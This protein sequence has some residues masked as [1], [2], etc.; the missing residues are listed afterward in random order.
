VFT[1]QVLR[2]FEQAKRHARARGLDEVTIES[3]L[4]AA[5][6]AG[7]GV[8]LARCLKLAANPQ[9]GHLP[10][11][12]AAALDEHGTILDLPM[13]LT[14]EVQSLI[15]CAHRLAGAVP[16][17][18]YP[19]LIG[20]RP[21]MCALAMSR[22]ACELLAARPISEKD[23]V[24]F[25]TIWYDGDEETPLL[26]ELA[27]RL[28]GLRGQLFSK[29]FGQDHAVQAFVEGLFSAEV[30]A[31]ADTTRKKPKAIFVFAGP[32]GVGKTYMA[33]LGAEA[34]GRP[35]RRFDMSAYSDHQQYLDLVGWPP[36]FQGAKPG[37]LTGYVKENPN[38]VL[39]FDEIEKAHLTTIN[40][41]LQLLDAGRLDDKFSNETVAFKDTTI[42]FTTN[43]GA[44][45]YDRPNETGVTVA[46]ASFHRRTILDALK[47]EK[48]PTGQPAF[49]QAICSR[50]AT[51]FPVLFNHLQVT[52][53]EMIARAELNRVTGLLEG[54]YFKCISYDDFLPLALVLR[55]GIATDARTI[56]AQSSAFV[57]TELFK[58]TELFTPQRLENVW[59]GTDQLH[60]G[61]ELAGAA[62][63]ISGLFIPPHPP[64][65]LLV[66]SDEI[67]ALYSQN[68][69][70]I[71]WHLA[72]TAEEGLNYLA[73]ADVDLILLDIWMGGSLSS[74]SLS[75]SIRA[76]DFM[77]LGSR[78]VAQG[79][80]FLRCVHERL[81]NIPVYLL[82]F[83]EDDQDSGSV[84]EGLLQACIRSGGAR[85]VCTTSFLSTVRP[86]W[87][88]QRQAFLDRLSKIALKMYR[89]TKAYSLGQEQK[90]LNFETMPQVSSGNRRITIQMKNL[91]LTRAFAAADVGEV[92]QN[93]E[94]PTVRFGDVYG[95]DSAKEAL[96]FVIDWLKN[97]RRYAALGIRP[98]KGILLTGNPG[99]GKTMLAR[100][101]AGESDVA[102]LVAS[103]TD[104]VT[105]WQGSGPQNIRDLFARARRY[106]PSIVFI[107][108]IDAVG[109]KRMGN[110]G[111][112]S[113]Q[114]EE[115]TLNALLTEMDGFGAPS[116]KPVIVL[117]ATNLADHLDD[118]LRRRFDREIE[119]PLPDKAA[120]A[121]FL[122][123]ELL[124]QA[125]THLSES[126]LDSI[127]ARSAGMT[128]A[129]LR[130][131]V[132]EAAVS[133]AR[134]ES[135]VT[136]AILEETFEKLR[137]GD[138]G[139][140]PDPATLERIARH[141]SG[142]AL[143]GWVLGNPM[144]QVTIIG[145]GSAGG[146]VEREAQEDK[147]IYTR[148]DLEGMICQSMGG[149]AAEI[150]Y[151]GEQEGLS[152][153]VA[154][155]L[156]QASS[157]AGRMIREFG[158][159]KEIGQI[160][161]DPRS[162]E[163]DLLAQVN[164]TAEDIVHNELDRAI[165]ILVNHR[166]RLEVLTTELL[167]KNRLVKA[168]LERILGREGE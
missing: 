24:Q 102:F 93:V 12:Q 64:R 3:L 15:D 135:A 79:Q 33:E 146:Y 158:M 111:G 87:Q 73:N 112:G 41:F 161:I 62:D 11:G 152:T 63:T 145:R 42:I 14:P 127:A 1:A 74:Q 156:Q 157:W 81:A 98:P 13:G 27:G 6:S 166:E 114:A 164:R 16:D 53:L 160:Y 129:D 167:E 97:P 23:A 95:A 116:L 120:R 155:D 128:I 109:K 69:P 92:V 136:D 35:F 43:A 82:S 147:M 121:T 48:G 106:A 139:Q 115:N 125:Y 70:E 28:R 108:E 56:R 58:L 144:V 77:P 36:S 118:A 150:L 100:A 22:P 110:A 37:L 71:D 80:N 29:I 60:F 140:T 85:G 8:L 99:T 153:G 7:G 122:K 32:P 131:L 132:N 165:T 59:Q 44:S 83:C 39:L 21:L 38:A 19:G 103:G 90:V 143:V 138:V 148:A 61:F 2:I 57:N 168:D 86:D 130:R 46:N 163:G 88:K 5:Q 113:H 137:V 67:G 10:G 26:S 142:H 151:Y 133:A 47:N 68:L 91:A 89:E 31:N 96:Q 154:S 78:A 104:F 124:D 34:L 76:F 123:H 72:K 51:G 18:T 17:R 52:E 119:V 149:R 101:V 107:D 25:L 162:L 49:P 141:E 84:D 126:V 117:A 20:L 105:I 50:L 66:A 54:Q 4:A 159:S 30:L 65:I 55:E 94:R 9:D 40:L 45:L 134:H 75:E